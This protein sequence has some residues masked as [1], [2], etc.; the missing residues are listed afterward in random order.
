MGD[1]FLCVAQYLLI[2]VVLAA[3]GGLGG[4]VG[5]RLRR[6][7]DARVAASKAEEASSNTTAEE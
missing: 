5:V 1:F 3:I 6:R 4:L 2:M 7:K